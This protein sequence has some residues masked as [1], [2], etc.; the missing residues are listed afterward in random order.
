MAAPQPLRASL[1]AGHPGALARPLATPP[2]ALTIKM[3]ISCLENSLSR[4]LEKRRPMVEC[5]KREFDGQAAAS[6]GRP[7][8]AQGA[9]VAFFGAAGLA[10]R[11]FALPSRPRSAHPAPLLPWRAQ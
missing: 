5:T 3:R 1:A 2:A 8:A 6:G 11:A 7:A 4:T 9:A 10:E